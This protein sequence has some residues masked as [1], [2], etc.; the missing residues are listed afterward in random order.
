MNKKPSSDERTAWVLSAA[1]C[2]GL[3]VFG[4]VAFIVGHVLEGHYR[5][6]DGLCNGAES[7]GLDDSTHDIVHCGFD[8]L[9]YSI[10]DWLHIG[11]IVAIAAGLLGVTAFLALSPQ[12]RD[13]LGRGEGA[14][15]ARA[16]GSMP[17]RPRAAAPARPDAPPPPP[18]VSG[19]TPRG[20]LGP[21]PVDPAAVGVKPSEPASRPVM[22]APTVPAV[23]CEECG[24]SVTAADRF[25]GGCGARV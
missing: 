7:V 14:V 25:C 6:L 12:V 4:G 19:V 8:T 23:F 10:G 9:M 16:A 20:W 2:L 3:A 1:S 15:P 22:T 13:G 5:L 17:H 24:A 18:K 21:T 11:A